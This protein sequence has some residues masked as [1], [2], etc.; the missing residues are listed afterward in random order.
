[1]P[2]SAA[3]MD[4]V[5]SHDVEQF[6]TGE[7]CD[8][9]TVAR[10]LGG[11]IRPR[12]DDLP[13]VRRYNEALLSL[14]RPFD[15][16][17]EFAESLALNTLDSDRI[18]PSF[19][20]LTEA[21]PE[22]KC[23]Y[24]DQPSVSHEHFAPHQRYWAENGYLLIKGLI[25]PS[26]C[27]EYLALREQL[28][29][30]RG[31]F[32]SF[33]P[34]LEH[35]VL[36]RMF[37]SAELNSMLTDLIGEEMGL[38]FNLSPFQSTERGWHQDDYLNPQGTFGRYAAVWIAVDDVP[39]DSGPFEFIRGSHK[40]PAVSRSKVIEYLKPEFRPDARN[41]QDWTG[42]AP[43]FVNPAYFYKFTL[44]K[45]PSTK[46]VGKKGD[47]LIWHSRLIHRGSPPASKDAIRPG[48]IGHYSAIRDT[49]WFGGNIRR[50]GGGGYYWHF[51]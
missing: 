14:Y 10:D 34:Y 11:I 15:A 6:L 26:T 19:D 30:G 5:K 29:L 48:V 47:V 42:R 1:M 46:F 8:Y 38:H 27:D 40:L 21:Y 25:D 50:H 44:D 43:M 18:L 33:T 13:A 41:L 39:A 32:P 23:P 2:R 28:A 36:R 37:C 4:I 20:E 17:T 7:V 12:P 49:R 3:D 24:L 51:D 31:G 9:A 45:M 16:S 22:T 35:E